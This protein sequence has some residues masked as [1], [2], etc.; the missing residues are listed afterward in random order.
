MEKWIPSWRSVPID[1][2]NEVAS[3]EDITQIS[4]FLNNLKGEKVKVRFCNR[5]NDQPMTIAHA[6]LALRNR[7][8]GRLSARMTLTLDGKE[9]I[10]LAPDT[11]V[12]SDEV[13]FPVTEEDDFL[14]S[15]YFREKTSVRT[16]C[17]TW[18][19]YT[20]QSAH[21]TG[22]FTQTDALGFTMKP[23]LAPG[24]AADPYPNQFVAGISDISVLTDGSAKLIAAFGDSITHMSYFSDPL[25]VML[26]EKFPGKCA[27]INGGICGN[28]LQKSFPAT[29]MP[30]GGHQF[31]IAG[32]DR[33]L[34]DLYQ[35]AC[36]DYVFLMEGVNDCSHSLVFQEETVPGAEDIYAAAR[37]IA[38][39]AKS[40]GS[41]FYL[42]TIT[43]FGA[44]GAPWR[45]AAEAIR[46][47]YND[48]IRT[49]SVGD[50][51]IDL[52][53]VM[54]DPD[55]PHKMQAAMHF[56]DGVHPNWAGGTKMAKAVFAKWFAGREAL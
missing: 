46:C 36:P 1:Y 3:F 44:A 4:T 37:Q 41:T 51:W 31:G 47:A 13:C 8:T 15:L 19:A 6:A 9:E 14:V 21:F 28:R 40:Y 33:F 5:Y 35:D 20:W 50:D 45:D 23:K 38:D 42:T 34:Q 24:M 22:D 32:K 12:Y 49:G 39:T 43:P 53:Q 7:V 18:A 16:V 29:P 27:V 52:D 48:L 11:Q 56:G 25:T 2:N 54:R 17:A 30:G 10:S 26:Y 55:D